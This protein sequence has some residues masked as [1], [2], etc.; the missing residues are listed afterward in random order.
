MATAADLAAAPSADETLAAAAVRAYLLERFPA[1]PYD[2]GPAADL[3]VA[4]SA[5]A[6]A[7][8]RQEAAASDVTLAEALAAGT[9]PATLTDQLAEAG[10]TQTPA[11]AA[12]GTIAVSLT[13]NQTL[14][15]ATAA[16]FTAVDGTTFSPDK[17]YQLLPT[18]STA[19]GSDQVVL[20]ASGARFVGLIG[21]VAVTAG[22]AGN[23][24]AGTPLTPPSEL[25]SGTAAY[26]AADFTGGVDAESAASLLARLEDAREPLTTASAGGLRNLVRDAAGTDTV[27]AVVGFGHAAN[28]R[29]L[30]AAGVYAPGRVDVTIRRPGA[31]GRVYV[32]VTATYV[33]TSGGFGVWQFTAAVPGASHP[34]RAYQSGTQVSLAGYPVTMT[35]RGYS[36]GTGHQFVTNVD[37]AGSAY[38]T[39]TG[40]FT[41][42]DTSISGLILGVS[43]K[44]YTVAVRAADAIDD[45]QDA[46][47]GAD[48]AAAGFDVLARGP[49]AVMVS[50]SVYFVTPVPS[51]VN[52]DAVKQA[53]ADAINATGLAT[54][55]YGSAA[56]AACLAAAPSG[57][58]ANTTSMSGAGYGRDAVTTSVVGTDKLVVTTDVNA[59]FTADACAFY[60]D[61]ANVT[62]SIF[63]G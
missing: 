55:V 27:V 63:A 60:C 48:A 8:V 36:G 14:A 30:V 4:P 10:L 59:G 5:A 31:L 57:S 28:R 62:L 40:R 19:T 11:T 20:V 53:Y 26:A 16:V 49:A 12:S 52:Q 3:V 39:V 33:A 61:P 37:A 32:T 38:A 18:G 17:S 13:A 45:C 41:D 15:I 9:D 25:P 2:G 46:F 7:A 1:L 51:A 43:T 44:S 24:P 21:G 54:T 50:A 29:A 56:A 22:A 42:P 23:K 47:D 34:E 6:L 35:A 58:R